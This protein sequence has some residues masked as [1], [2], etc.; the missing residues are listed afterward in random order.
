M[1]KCKICGKE[2]TMPFHT[3]NRTKTMKCAVS[4]CEN[5]A[6]QKVAI[7]IN[8]SSK[9]TLNVCDIHAD[10]AREDETAE[11]INFYDPPRSKN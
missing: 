9:M 4:D 11:W 8:N 3:C 6:T 2:T 10:A 1:K 7:S 5:T